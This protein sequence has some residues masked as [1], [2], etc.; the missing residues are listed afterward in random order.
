MTERA[1]TNLNPDASTR[2]N[3]F[4]GLTDQPADEIPGLAAQNVSPHI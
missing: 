2:Q 3:A 4:A 1:F